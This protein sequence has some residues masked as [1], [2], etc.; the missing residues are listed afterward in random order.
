MVLVLV[1]WRGLL[2]LRVVRSSPVVLAGF[3]VDV[4]DAESNMG[5]LV[6]VAML[7]GG[8]ATGA[9]GVAAVLMVVSLQVA[10]VRSS[11]SVLAFRMFEEPTVLAV[12]GM[13]SSGVTG[14][15]C[16]SG[17][18]CRKILLCMPTCFAVLEP[19]C[20]ATFVFEFGPYLERASVNRWYSWGVH[21]LLLPAS[22]VAAWAARCSLAAAACWF[23]TCWLTERRLGNLA[24]QNSH[25]TGPASSSER[26]GTL[27]FPWV[28]V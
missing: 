22:S 13:P 18:S 19:M 21:R 14:L 25:T 15:Y 11:L 6:V 2:A 20:D 26:V 4:P 12:S 1:M 5:S 10:F 16:Q 7:M 23:L 17:L 27:A 24:S 28:L 8:S 3:L 9:G